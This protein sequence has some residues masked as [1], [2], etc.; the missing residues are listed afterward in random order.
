MNGYSHIAPRGFSVKL[1]RE[2]L[3]RKSR[4]CRMEKWNLN[5]QGIAKEKSMDWKIDSMRICIKPC[6]GQIIV[7]ATQIS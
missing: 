5:M 4:I 3:N 6:G 1:K 2:S 7:I